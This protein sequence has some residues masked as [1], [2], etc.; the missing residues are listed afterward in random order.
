MEMD[1][2]CEREGEKR[3]LTIYDTQAEKERIV[4]KRQY[5]WRGY[6]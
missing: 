6:Q 5:Q 1:A 4:S 3:A 2:Y